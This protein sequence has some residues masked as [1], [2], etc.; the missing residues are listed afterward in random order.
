MALRSRSASAVRAVRAAA[1]RRLSVDPRALV[2]LRVALATLLLADLALRARSLRF[3]YTDAGSLPRAALTAEFPVV[4]RLSLH[5]LFGGAWWTVLLFAL[6]AVAALAMLGGYRTR[7]AAVC[8][9]LL[10][11][12]LHA[13]NPLVLNG[14]DSLLRRTLL[15]SLFLPLGS[16]LSMGTVRRAVAGGDEAGGSD[17]GDGGDAAGRV[18]SVERCTHPAAAAL[19][20]QPVVVYAVN[21]VIKLRGSAWPSGRAVR[22]VFRIDSLTVLFGDVLAGYPTV[23][24][25]LGIGWLAL[26]CG[27]P[28][29]LLTTGRARVAVVA[30]FAAAHVGMA[31]T[32]GV[33]LFPLIS[34][35]ALLPYLPTRVWDAVER[36]W[37]PAAT[38]LRSI[39][40]AARGAAAGP[41]AA[42]IDGVAR[43]RERASVEGAE[44]PNRARVVATA[45]RAGR[46]VAAAGLVVVVAWNAA[47]LGYV[48]TPDVGETAVSPG[49]TRWDMFAPAPPRNDVWYVAR[50]TL[51]SGGSVEVIRGG[52]F[53]WER[54]DGPWTSYPS[55]RWRK[56]LEVVRWSDDDRLRRHFAAALCD[57]WRWRHGGEP[58]DRVVVYAVVE[59]VEPDGSGEVRRERVRGHDCPAGG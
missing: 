46:V 14:G 56:Y 15:W 6:A 38:R 45:G 35:A 40:T 42:P 44:S 55:A 10:L 47:A 2:A 48:D 58:L 50:G 11:V 9:W 19:L 20:I 43:A 54:P 57:R 31:L 8:S 4:A 24:T 32:L 22:T 59:P 49:E 17:G 25:V 53:T 7:T 37:D 16:G 39:G 18:G 26:L 13:R 34:V 27:S 36:R 29:L 33:G 1:V 3:F 41:L 30:A 5:A 52:E 23:L 28:L 12:S 51:R 21:A